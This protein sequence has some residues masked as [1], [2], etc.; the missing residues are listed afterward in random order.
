MGPAEVSRP[1]NVSERSNAPAPDSENEPLEINTLNENELDNFIASESDSHTYF[2]NYLTVSSTILIQ[3]TGRRGILRA[4][5]IPAFRRHLEKIL[6]DLSKTAKRHEHFQILIG[7]KNESANYMSTPFYRAD[8][9]HSIARVMS[10]IN[11]SV[12]SNTKWMLDDKI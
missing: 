11:Q 12:H 4:Q 3:V 10:L 5:H 7:C 8:E 9:H 6:E 2:N 1:E